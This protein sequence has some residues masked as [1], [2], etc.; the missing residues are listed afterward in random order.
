M[1]KQTA[2][3]LQPGDSIY[4]A[5]DQGTHKKGREFKVS[6]VVDVAKAGKTYI[7]ANDAETDKVATFDVAFW[8]A[9]PLDG[10]KSAPAKQVAPDA[11]ETAYADVEGELAEM[12]RDF[13]PAPSALSDAFFTALQDTSGDDTSLLDSAMSEVTVARGAKW[14][15]TQVSQMFHQFC[16]DTG[17]DLP[18]VV[19]E[20][21]RQ[22]GK[23]TKAAN[24]VPVEQTT[25]EAPAKP[26]RGRPTKAE[27]EAKAA[28][29]PKA[30]ATESSDGDEADVSVALRIAGQALIHL[31]DAQSFGPT[32]DL[33]AKLVSAALNG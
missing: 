8:S 18:E 6:R 30:E 3:K 27:A 22:H 23:G 2:E 17:M 29:K 14:T 21:N 5:Q 12:F 25:E 1:D 10:A 7:T 28:V 13:A 32:F 20:F 19:L 31:A 16:Q 4:L 11:P 26:K 9:E 33:A 24:H 15:E